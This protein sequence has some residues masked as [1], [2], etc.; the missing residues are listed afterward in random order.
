[1]SGLSDA[2]AEVRS[3]AWGM[4]E[5]RSLYELWPLRH[6]SVPADIP[7]AGCRFLGLPVSVV[8]DMR[9]GVFRLATTTGWM[10]AEFPI[11]TGTA[12]GAA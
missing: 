11:E 8:P 10:S 9:P 2:Y 5:V 1:M 3:G 7:C 6:P 4:V 12:R